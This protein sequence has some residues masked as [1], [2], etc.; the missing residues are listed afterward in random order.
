MFFPI[1]DENP[2]RRTPVV[3][4]GLITLNV[5]F[6]VFANPRH[7]TTAYQEFIDTYGFRASV[8]FSAQLVTSMFLHANWMHLLGNMWFLHLFGDNVEDKLG[9]GRYLLLYLVGGIAACWAYSFVDRISPGGGPSVVVQMTELG[10]RQIIWEPPLVGASGA[11]AAVTGLY[12]VLF[13]EARIRVLVWF[14]FFVQFLAIRAK[15]FLGLTLAL[16]LL[17]TIQARGP[18]FGTVATSAHVGGALF[19][20]LAAVALKR[21]IGGRGEGDAWDVHTGFSSV[22]IDA[23]ESDGRGRPTSRP[24]VDPPE[25]MLIAREHTLVELARSGR[26]A[27]AARLYPSYES[28]SREKPLP[29]DVQIEIAHEFYK[30]ALPLEALRAYARYVET[31][32][33]GADAAE[34]KFRMGVLEA[35]AFNR[36]SAAIRLLRAALAEHPDPQVA[37]YAR[38]ELERL[39]FEA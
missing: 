3:T 10:P 13:P 38:Q 6:F 4:W 28:L 33:H 22:E 20:M 35:R 9:R 24:P 12:L 34:A 19:G 26:T 36:R 23:P 32:P 25:H 30:Q 1:G 2:T 18:A 17:R 21:H 29:G 11:I 39:G 5:V 27:E 14:F 8:P 37:E 16:D 15:W 7:G 31:H